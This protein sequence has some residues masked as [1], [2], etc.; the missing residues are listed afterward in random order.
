MNS[1]NMLSEDA[2]LRQY[3]YDDAVVFVGD[4]GPTRDAV[5]DVVDDT[6]IVVADDEEYDLDLPAGDS[7]AFIHNGIL[8]VE[9]RT[10]SEATEE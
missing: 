2:S 8:T 9:V 5:V 1:T 10:E 7:Q 6:A 3:E 4:L